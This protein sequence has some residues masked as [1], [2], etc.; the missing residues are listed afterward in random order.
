MS[1]IRVGTRI[2]KD[3]GDLAE[4]AESIRQDG[5]LNPIIVRKTGND[6]YRLLAGCRRLK[7]C[8]MLKMTHIECI[9]RRK[10]EG[11]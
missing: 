7:A 11:Q 8:R 6:S 2:R 5:L 9:I 1:Q 4:L 10:G 3:N